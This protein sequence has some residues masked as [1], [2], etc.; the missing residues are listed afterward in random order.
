MR[1]T[2]LLAS[3]VLLFAHSTPAD[4]GLDALRR[5]LPELLWSL[6]QV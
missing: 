4:E 3:A 6:A 2:F 5:D 1:R